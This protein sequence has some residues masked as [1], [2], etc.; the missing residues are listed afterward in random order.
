MRFFTYLFTEKVNKSNLGHIMLWI[1]LIYRFKLARSY[2]I[3]IKLTFFTD[4]VCGNWG[5]VKKLG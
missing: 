2:F 4:E 3:E 1:F 5:Y